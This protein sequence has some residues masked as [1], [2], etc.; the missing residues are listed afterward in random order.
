MID[1]IGL[2]VVD[3]EG[4]QVEPAQLEKALQELDPELKFGVFCTFQSHTSRP[5]GLLDGRIDAVY[6]LHE[7]TLTIS[8]TTAEEIEKALKTRTP[9]T[10][11]DRG[12]Q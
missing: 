12:K 3:K 6:F 11:E 7:T 1:V 2:K 9:F 10:Y 4:W 8:G 5:Y